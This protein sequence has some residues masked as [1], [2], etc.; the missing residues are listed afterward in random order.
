MENDIIFKYK[1]PLFFSILQQTK[2]KF[3]KIK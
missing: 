3:P 2:Q 1:K